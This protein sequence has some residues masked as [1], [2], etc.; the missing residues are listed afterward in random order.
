VNAT[1][2][3]EVFPALSAARATSVYVPSSV[4]L[5]PDENGAPFSVTDELE[6]FASVAVMTG[7]TASS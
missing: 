1:V 2:V 7:V 4:I 3:W 5:V 6:R